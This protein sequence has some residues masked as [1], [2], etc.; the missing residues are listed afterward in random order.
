[1]IFMDICVYHASCSTA[2]KYFSNV[3][4]FKYLSIK[5]KLAK[6]VNSL[7]SFSEYLVYFGLSDERIQLPA[8]AML[9]N[10]MKAANIRLI[11]TNAIAQNILKLSLII[12]PR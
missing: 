1:M 12:L 5:D 4:M 2:K 10:W 8:V 7:W 11:Q 6:Q 3:L 9:W